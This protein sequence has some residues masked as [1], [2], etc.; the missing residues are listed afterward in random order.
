[1]PLLLALWPETSQLP[2]LD[3][4]T[5]EPRFSTRPTGRGIAVFQLPSGR[6]VQA[7]V[8][9]HDYQALAKETH[10]SAQI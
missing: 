3:P 7:P 6:L 4:A 2:F 10:F 9:S 8:G 1:M 5:F